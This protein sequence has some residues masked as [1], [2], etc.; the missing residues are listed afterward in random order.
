MKRVWE[1]EEY[2]TKVSEAQTAFWN[3]SEGKEMASKRAQTIWANPEHQ[4]A[5]SILMKERMSDPE[6]KAIAVTALNTK[7]TIEK[8]S[9][10]YRDRLVSE[11]EFLA[12]M[13]AHGRK[14][15]AKRN[16]SQPVK[17][18]GS[19][20]APDGTVYPSISH[21]PT[22]AKTHGL[23]KQNLYALLCGKVKSHKGWTLFIENG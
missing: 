5:M 14:N 12:K 22:F 16:S 9:Q 6:S 8:R 10:T 4:E 2:R 11:P 23:Q 18:Y 1:N 20:Q 13:Q 15:I 19:V 17:T 3:T 21:V 7:E